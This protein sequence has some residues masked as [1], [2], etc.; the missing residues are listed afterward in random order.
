MAPS[1]PTAPSKTPDP[2]SQE[3]ATITQLLGALL[4]QERTNEQQLRKL[5]QTLGSIETLLDGFSS[6]GSS[7][8]AYQLDPMLLTYAA[9]LGPILGDRIDSQVAKGDAYL[10]EMLKGAAVMARRLLQTLDE[11]RQQ[12]SGLDY[13]EHQ[14]GDIN[15]PAPPSENP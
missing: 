1:S 14:A 5:N 9:I 6:G 2:G 7:F 12:R 3:L 8:R 4:N 10:D 15:E 11:Y 13:L